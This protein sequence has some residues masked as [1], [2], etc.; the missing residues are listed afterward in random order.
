MFVENL[1]DVLFGQQPV[2]Q[3]QFEQAED[4]LTKGMRGLSVHTLL[5]R[6][7]VISSLLFEL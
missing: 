5:Y 3:R 7:K 4:R 2:G 6:L 1:E